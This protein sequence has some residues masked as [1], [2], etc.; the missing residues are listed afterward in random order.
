MNDQ[1]S[2]PAGTREL[3]LDAGSQ[4]FAAKGFDG[5]SVREI[6][7]RAGTNLGSITYHFGSKA[8]L[9]EAVLSRHQA[10]LLEK[11]E[12]A[13]WGP[14]TTLERLE[15]VVTTHFAHLA[16]HPEVRRLMSQVLLGP[17]ALPAA[18]AQNVRRMMGVVAGLIARGQTEGVFRKGDPRLL[19][20][21]VMSQPIM[22]NVMRGPLR[23]GSQIEME[24]PAVRSDL[25]EN[26]LRFIRAGLL[27]SPGREV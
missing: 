10:P 20:I 5:S 4:V 17:T 13:A 21:A 3:L 24:D 1:G 23:A 19:T 14:G 16:E 18:A 26:A 15:A 25:L 11:M 12:V 8:G 7:A 27:R 6:T 22:L 9:F 2:P